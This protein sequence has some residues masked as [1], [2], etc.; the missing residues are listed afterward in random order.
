MKKILLMLMIV[1][2]IATVAT[3]LSTSFAETKYLKKEEIKDTMA[4]FTKALG[5][6]CNFCHTED[7]SQNYQ[8]LGGQTADKD[9]LSALAHKS[10]ARAMLG[11]ML[12]LNQKE[13]KNY[14]CNTCHQGKTEVQVGRDTESK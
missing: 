13:G 2:T 3:L 7:R 9:Q 14:T 11:S 8:S 4:G 10:I 1:F 6:K 5:V 12:Y